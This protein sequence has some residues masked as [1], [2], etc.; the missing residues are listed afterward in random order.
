MRCLSSCSIHNSLFRVC[1]G[2]V[3]LL[4]P[5]SLFVVLL[6]VVRLILSI[7]IGPIMFL[8]CTFFLLYEKQWPVIFEIECCCER[9]VGKN[10]WRKSWCVAIENDWM[11]SWYY[12][13]CM[14]IVMVQPKWPSWCF[15]SY[16]WTLDKYCK[17]CVVSMTVLII[18]TCS[19]FQIKSM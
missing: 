18:D 10:R 8:T 2:F 14:I 16:E 11:N 17:E 4:F 3:V 1:M 5:S 19:L 12:V 9:G 13:Y 7:G 15:W 6:F